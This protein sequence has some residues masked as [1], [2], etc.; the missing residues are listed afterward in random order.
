MPPPGPS[1]VLGRRR[2][3]RGVV[4]LCVIPAGLAARFLLSGG[5]ADLAGGA[6]Y[7]VLIYLLVG[8]IKPGWAPHR[9]A[10]L[11]FVLSCAVELLQLTALPGALSA[12]VP[13]LRLVLGTTFSAA[14][15]PAYA[16]GAVLILIV[17]C[18]LTRR[19]QR[20]S[21]QSASTSPRQARDGSHYG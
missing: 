6:F 16:L 10:L 9:L 19:R 2:L 17:D 15:L 1:P 14:D 7:A 13:P 4:A 3:V 5:I 20:T 8:V 11:A 18:L 21:R 12:L